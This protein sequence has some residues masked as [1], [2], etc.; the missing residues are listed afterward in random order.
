MMDRNL[1]L[2][3]LDKKN[4]VILEDSIFYIINILEVVRGK[5]IKKEELSEESLDKSIQ[6]LRE[7]KSLLLEV[8][9]GL[10]ETKINGYT[11]SKLYLEKYLNDILDGIDKLTKDEE[12]LEKEELIQHINIL[13]DLA[14]KY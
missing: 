7:I 9:K 4:S 14:L 5:I 2:K 3:L 13:I 11:N 12:K 8:L 10:K 1:I 6:K